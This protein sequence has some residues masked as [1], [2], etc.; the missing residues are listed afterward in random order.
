MESINQFSE[1]S[2][3]SFYNRLQEIRA[4]KLGCASEEQITNIRMFKERFGFDLLTFYTDNE[5]LCETIFTEVQDNSSI[6]D[7]DP[8]VAEVYSRL[9]ALTLNAPF[10]NKRL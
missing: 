4:V 1:P 3:V 8:L 10:L 9:D 5:Q 2:Y 7:I 6:V